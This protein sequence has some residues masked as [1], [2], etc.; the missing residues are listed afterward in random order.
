MKKIIYNNDSP[1]GLNKNQSRRDEIIIENKTN[2]IN[3]NPKGMI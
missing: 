1:S 2:E 3:N